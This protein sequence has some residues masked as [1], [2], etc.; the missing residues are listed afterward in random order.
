[1]RYDSLCVRFLSVVLAARD[2]LFFVVV[3]RPYIC[4][5]LPSNLLLRKIG[6]RYLMPSLLTLWGLMVAL[7]G[8]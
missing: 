6:P 7:Q 3:S 2:Q 1:M 5:E 8:T 4:A